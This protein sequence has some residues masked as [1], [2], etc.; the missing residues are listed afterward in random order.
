MDVVINKI[1]QEVKEKW[2]KVLHDHKEL[3]VEKQIQKVIGIPLEDVE[4]I[5]IEKK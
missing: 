3:S 2:N 1:T 5:I 4:N